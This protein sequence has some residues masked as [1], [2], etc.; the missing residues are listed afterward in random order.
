[1]KAKD[2]NEAQEFASEVIV[3]FRQILK[4]QFFTS[5]ACFYLAYFLSNF[6]PSFYVLCGVG[7]A[8]LFKNYS[9]LMVSIS[10]V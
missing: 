3:E 6:T 7:L 1:M 10:F 9:S 4:W 5:F 2:L 8:L